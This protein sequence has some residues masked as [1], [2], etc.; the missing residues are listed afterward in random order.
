M[1]RIFVD[2]IEKY[3]ERKDL[4]IKRVLPIATVAKSLILKRERVVFVGN[5]RTKGK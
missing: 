1:M 5:R 2:F 4:F 3:F